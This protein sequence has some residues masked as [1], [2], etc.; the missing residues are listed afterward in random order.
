MLYPMN[1]R[2]RDRDVVVIGGGKVAHRKVLGLLDAGAKVKVVSP[3]LTS[4]L[5]SLADADRISWHPTSYEEKDLEGALLIIAATNDH[6]TNLAVKMDAA[7]HQLVNLADDPAESDFQVPSFMKRGRLT[8]A[9]STSGASPILAKKIC[10]QLEQ[11]FDEQYDSYLEFLAA[12]R[13]KI[14][15]SVKDGTVKKQL[16]MAITDSSFLESDE[17]EGR[18]AALLE[19]AIKEEGQ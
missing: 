5:L 17:R 14:I 10:T 4:D 6:D 11:T 3:E 2:I 19:E 9:V 12:C 8:I 16:L 1:V 13:K 18:F 15:S 7:P